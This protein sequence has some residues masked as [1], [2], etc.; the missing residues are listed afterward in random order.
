MISWKRLCKDRSEG[1]GFGDEAKVA[2]V[3][4]SYK[5]ALVL[6]T[7]ISH[8][9]VEDKLVWNI[10][11]NG[12]FSVKKAYEIIT[13]NTH[14]HGSP[15]FKW[16][17]FWQLPFTQRVLLFW[18]KNLNKGLPLKMNLA[19]KGFQI[20]SNCPYG[21]DAAETEE[22]I[23]KDCQYAQRVWFASRPNLRSDDINASSM[24]EWIS[25]KIS[26]LSKTSPPQHKEIVMLLLSICWSLYTQRNQLLFQQ[27]KPDVT[28]CLN[29]AYKIVDEIIGIDTIQRQ[30]HFF[31][32]EVP[33][34]QRG[35]G[36]RTTEHNVGRIV[37]TFSWKKDSSTMRKVFA[38]FQQLEGNQ[39]L[40]CSMVTED[41]QDD[42]LALL[43]SVRLF[44]EEIKWD[45][46][47]LTS[48]ARTSSPN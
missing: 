14:T 16:N 30:D 15:G 17:R 46:S 18:W 4:T 23:F 48:P 35:D 6:D 28:K 20:S 25:Q 34:K 13:N 19:R 26:N 36:S 24:S 1:G 47:P 8:T 2:Q 32:L 7:V 9:N 21:C 41:D 3:Y 31:K 37:L 10:T 39:K 11:D 45:L 27:G 33:R 38:I 43:R 12:D 29:K 22:H 42:C 44:L 5:K 40:L